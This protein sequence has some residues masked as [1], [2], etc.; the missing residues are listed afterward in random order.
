M[1]G[2]KCVGVFCFVGVKREEREIAIK[3]KNLNEQN[4]TTFVSFH[5]FILPKFQRTP[6]MYTSSRLAFATTHHGGWVQRYRLRVIRW[7]W[8][9]ACIDTISVS[10]A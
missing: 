7:S 5:T 4:S 6:S 3:D 9:D 2:W 1:E 10:K 8:V